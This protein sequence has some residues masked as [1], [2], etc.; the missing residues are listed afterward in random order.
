MKEKDAQ[1]SSNTFSAASFNFEVSDGKLIFYAH[2]AFLIKKH[3]INHV[4]VRHVHPG[5]LAPFHEA[6]AS[7]QERRK[8]RKHRVNS[9]EFFPFFIPGSPSPLKNELS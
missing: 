1:C 8:K 5:Q 2:T 6:E 4:S 9:I 3:L 7:V